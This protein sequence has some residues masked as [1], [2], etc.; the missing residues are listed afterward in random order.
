MPREVTNVEEDDEDTKKDERALEVEVYMS[1]GNADVI[2]DKDTA[3]FDAIYKNAEEDDI[4]LVTPKAD[5]PVLNR[6][7]DCGSAREDLWRGHPREGYQEFR[8]RR[9]DL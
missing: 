4:V 8:D 3:G 6:C 7:S 9:R 5:D 2:L 1:N